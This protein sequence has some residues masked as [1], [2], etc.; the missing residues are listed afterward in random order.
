MVGY[1]DPPKEHQ[2]KEGNNA[3]PNG[4]GGVPSFKTV[5]SKYLSGE[6]DIDDPITQKKMK[7]T[8]QDALMLKKIGMALEGNLQAINSIEDRVDGKPEQ[9]QDITSKG[10]KIPMVITPGEGDL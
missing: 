9:H 2:F 6:L 3:N 8:V 7:V 10:E 5:L 4:R 1:K